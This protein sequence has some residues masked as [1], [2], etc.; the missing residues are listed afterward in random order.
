M[1]DFILVFMTVAA[2]YVGLAGLIYLVIAKN[3]VGD[4]DEL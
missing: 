1:L 2:I 3:D 4:S